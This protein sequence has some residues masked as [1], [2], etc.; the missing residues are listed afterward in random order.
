[1]FSKRVFNHYKQEVMV[2]KESLECAM[3]LKRVFS[4]CKQEVTLL[5]KRQKLPL[6]R[7]HKAILLNKS[8][9]EVP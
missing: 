3:F 5:S 6:S 2:F 7:S 4:H 9:Q 1:M 8:S